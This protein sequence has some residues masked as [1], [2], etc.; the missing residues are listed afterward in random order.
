MSKRRE[1]EKAKVEN[2]KKMKHN[3]EEERRAINKEKQ[4]LKIAIS[5]MESEKSKNRMEMGK[6]KAL[7]SKLVKNVEKMKL[8]LVYREALMTT[9][10]NK[11]ASVGRISKND[12]K[13][14]YQKK[15]D[16]CAWAHASW[17]NIKN[18][19]LPKP[20]NREH[21]MYKKASKVVI[22]HRNSNVFFD[23]GAKRDAKNYVKLV[24]SRYG[25]NNVNKNTNPCGLKRGFSTLNT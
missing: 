5:E 25:V 10:L 22:G 13:Q 23:N 4:Q 8:R 1:R 11:L 19:E 16:L 21:P 18:V 17:K 2:L 9:N 3:I 14:Y 7:V 15:D 24:N 6:N 12:R 20:T